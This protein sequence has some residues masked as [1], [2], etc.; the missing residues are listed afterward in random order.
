MPLHLPYLSI[1]WNW[2]CWFMKRG[3]NRRTLSKSSQS[4]GKRETTNPTLCSRP[5][6]A[7]R[8]PTSLTCNVTFEIAKK[9]WERGSKPDSH[10]AWRPKLEPR[11]HR[12]R[13]LLSPLRN[14]CYQCDEG[15]VWV[16]TSLPKSIKSYQ[17]HV[18]CYTYSRPLFKEPMRSLMLFR[19]THISGVR[20]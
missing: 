13:R 14:P 8:V 7:I 16:L 15:W 20:M 9:D 1:N 4:R 3:E 18:S 11:S 2:K 12:C 17:F 10:K 19:S 5:V 6:R